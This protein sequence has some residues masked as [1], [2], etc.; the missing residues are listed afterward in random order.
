MTNNE[1]KAITA[2]TMVNVGLVVVI[3]ASVWRGATWATRL[4]ERQE[5]QIQLLEYKIDQLR[6]DI[7]RNTDDRFRRSDMLAYHAMADTWIRVFAA[8]NPDLVVPNWPELPP[9][10]K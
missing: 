1:A 9:P 6:S 3:L 5:H 10:S 2:S 4:E 8:G 7:S